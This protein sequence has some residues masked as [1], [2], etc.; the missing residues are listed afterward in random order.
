MADFY[1]T[2]GRGGRDG[3]QSYSLAYTSSEEVRTVRYL[4]TLPDKGPYGN[5]D[6]A[7][8]TQQEKVTAKIGHL[9]VVLDYLHVGK[10]R[11]ASILAYFGEVIDPKTQCNKTWSVLVLV[12]VLVLVFFFFLKLLFTLPQ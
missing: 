9:G 3:L 1:Q 12:L 4:V 10:C 7:S 6:D 8:E 5:Q 2:S 11:R